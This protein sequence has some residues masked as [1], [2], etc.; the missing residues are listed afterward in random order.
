MLDSTKERMKNVLKTLPIVIPIV[1]QNPPTM[2]RSQSA[3]FGG[4]RRR[5]ENIVMT[6]GQQWGIGSSE[7]NSL[8]EYLIE[9]RRVV[10]SGRVGSGRE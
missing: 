4:Y 6:P 10:W 9:K 1:A 3:N 2:S 5:V 8:V 7:R